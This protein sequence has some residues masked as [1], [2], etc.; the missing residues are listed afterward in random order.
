[1]ENILKHNV[2]SFDND[3]PPGRSHD[4]DMLIRVMKGMHN[5]DQKDIEALCQCI[6]MLE[7]E[8]HA[9]GKHNHELLQTSV[10]EKQK[11]Q[12]ELHTLKGEN[13]SLIHEVCK[14]IFEY[15]NIPHPFPHSTMLSISC[16]HSFFCSRW[17]IRTGT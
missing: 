8:K 4:D 10:N 2:L 7:E 14:F 12:E 17:T 11:L 5:E 6:D 15:K 9:L 3:C 13:S 1:M 16:I